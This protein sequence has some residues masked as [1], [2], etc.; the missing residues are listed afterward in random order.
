MTDPTWQ[1]S[2]TDAAATAAD[3]TTVEPPAT[4]PRRWR[5]LMVLA[6]VQFMF[7]LDLTVVN[8]ALPHIQTVLDFSVSG[9]AW[10]VNAYVLVAG[11]FL[12]L[13]G[14]LGDLLGRRSVFLAGTAVFGLAS[15]LCGV[16][17]DSSILVA[18]RF[19][20]GLGEALAAPAGLGIVARMFTDPSERSK[21][22]GLWTGLAAL[23]GAF[24]IILSGLINEW[25]SWRWVFYINLPVAVFAL[26]AVPRLVSAH[27]G[28]RPVRGGS[29]V[30]GAVLLTSSMLA[31][32]YGLLQGADHD[33][34]SVRVAL[35]IVLGVV[36]M[37]LFVLLESRLRQPLVPLSFFRHRVRAIACITSVAFASGFF[38]TFFLLTLYMQNVLG[39]TPLRTGLAYLP[40]ALTIIIGGGFAAT[41]MTKLGG[42]V[43]LV[44]GCV[45]AGTGL[46]VLSGISADGTYLGDILAGTVLVGLGAGL[47][48]PTLGTTA[49]QEVS[50]DNSGLA[51]GV[52]NSS[53]QTGGALGLAVLA[54]IA[55]R[56]TESLSATRDQAAAVVGGYSVALLVGAAILLVAA[57]LAGLLMPTSAGK[58]VQAV[59][60]AAG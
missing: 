9:I 59:G 8:V 43:L 41:M 56:R 29:D 42:R 23:G 6:V 16:A 53:Y 32:V 22:V 49:L 17:N 60:P 31:V 27:N 19:L 37:A 3:P 4:D 15:L 52:Q 33:W 44:A 13:G 1:N 54:T 35:P 26:I 34:G 46:A 48:F 20:Q 39:W 36:L 14:R 7:V 50:D 51:A 24:G 30:A 18:G 28:E 38:A 55:I 40:M 11:G 12:L 57:V 25:A 58:D 21:A 5:A 45:L 2:P 10:V 47:T